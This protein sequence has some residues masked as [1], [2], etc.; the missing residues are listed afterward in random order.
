MTQNL[1]I[2]YVE[3]YSSEL[4]ETQNFFSDAFG[5][6][7]VEYGSDYRDI[8]GAGTGA[9]LERSENKAPLIVLR[10]ND[11][12]AALDQVRNAGAKITKE[13]FIFPGGRRFEF[14]EP[15]GTLMAVWCET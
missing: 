4:E 5:W 15:G 14:Q 2:D 7:F 3:F 13:I 8:Q 11:L 6:S 1:Q 9:G 10:A 12:E